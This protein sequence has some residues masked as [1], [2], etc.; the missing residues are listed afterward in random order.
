M[1][2]IFECIIKNDRKSLVKIL[3]KNSKDL[4]ILD[5]YG[6]TPLT[7]ATIDGKIELVET[8]IE[9]KA[10]I[11][12]KDNDERTALHFAAQEYQIGI[13]KLLLENG[14]TVDTRDN[15]GNTPLS[16]AVFY[17]E[18]RGEIIELLLNYGADKKLKND[19]DVSP[20]ELAK[21]IDN[22]NV[23]QFFK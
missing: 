7:N 14:V 11:D 10:D 6:R 17:S 3:K 15:N 4:N 18:G 2:N 5:R 21:S 1:K 8:L 13:V 22:Y 12:S 16:D 23:K 20:I 9:Y 19:Y